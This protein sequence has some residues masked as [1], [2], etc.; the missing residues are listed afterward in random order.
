MSIKL[1]FLGKKLENEISNQELGRIQDC[2]HVENNV[3]IKFEYMYKFMLRPLSTQAFVDKS[4]SVS[5][6]SSCCIL[7]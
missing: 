2:V 3:N 7:L 6:W 4:T 1:I 5:F